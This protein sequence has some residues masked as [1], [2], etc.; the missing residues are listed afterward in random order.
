[1]ALAECWSGGV[2]ESWRAGELESW[3]AGELES[4][5]AGVL[6]CWGVGGMV[7]GRDSPIGRVGLFRGGDAS[8]IAREALVFGQ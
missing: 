3:R 1:M 4:W 2:V 6:E 5:S 8:W 7:E